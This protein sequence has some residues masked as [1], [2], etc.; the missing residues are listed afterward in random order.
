MKNSASI[1]STL[2]L[3]SFLACKKADEPKFSECIESKI[4]EFKQQPWADSIVKIKKPGETL[5]WFVDT[6]VDAG[7]GVFNEN[8]DLICTTDCECDGDFLFC[9][10]T[11]L[12]F[13]KEVVW[14]K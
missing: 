6:T 1:V 5:Y 7:E 2:F 9:D 14:K 11:H 10:E 12:H 8:C 3:F 4:E 13:P